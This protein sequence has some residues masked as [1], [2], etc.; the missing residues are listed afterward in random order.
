MRGDEHAPARRGSPGAIVSS[1]YGTKRATVSLSDSVAGNVRGG[2]AVI[3]RVVR[4]MP[5]I[6][7]IERRRRRVVAS[8]PD[9]DLRLAVPGGRFGLVQPLQRPV[10]AFV[11]P[12][13]PD[14][15][16]PEQVELVERDPARA[17]RALQDG[18]EG[19]VK[20]PAAVAEQHTGIA[21]LDEALGTEID[22]R[23]A[24]EPVFAVP[25]AFAV[26]KKNDFVHGLCE[27]LDG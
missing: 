12:P 8:P 14:H 15:R 20:D 23:P 16:N 27:L 6:A 24:R 3:A 26:T 21:G 11:E 7:Q 13:V 9:L 2:E 22:I 25:G 19:D 17:D 4:G 1:Q 5:R 18:R 10:M